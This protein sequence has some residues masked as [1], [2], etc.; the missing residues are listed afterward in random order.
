MAKDIHEL[1]KTVSGEPATVI[2]HD[3]GMMVAYAYAAQ[4]PQDTQKVAL[5]DALPLDTVRTFSPPCKGGSNAL[6]LFQ[7]R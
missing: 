4:Y 6:R 1:V 3:I 5:M 2:G 7:S